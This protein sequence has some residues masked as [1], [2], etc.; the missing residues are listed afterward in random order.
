[1]PARTAAPAP[2][3]HHQQPPVMMQQPQ[4]PSLFKQMAAT[5]G[6][7]AVG[8]AVVSKIT[9]ILNSVIFIW[10]IIDLHLGIIVSSQ[11]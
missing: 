4:Q 2:P 10:V 6:G 5:A 3:A 7:V 1:M 11:E 8:S 9:K